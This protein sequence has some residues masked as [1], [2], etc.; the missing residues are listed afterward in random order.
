MEWARLVP[1]ILIKQVARVPKLMQ[2]ASFVCV[3]VGAFS[4]IFLQIFNLFNYSH[5][6]LEGAAWP[7]RGARCQGE[8]LAADHGEKLAQQMAEPWA[9]G[10]MDDRR[11]N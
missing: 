7:W 2:N 6:L 4:H 8:A 11:T 3:L 10:R 9:D 5:I 1:K